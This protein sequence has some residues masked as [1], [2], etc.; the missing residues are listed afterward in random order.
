MVN[1]RKVQEAAVRF[2]AVQQARLFLGNSMP[3]TIVRKEMLDN[4]IDVVSERKMPAHKAIFKMSP[5][6]LQ[7][8]DDGFGISTVDNGNDTTDLWKA[9]SKLFT[10]SNY[11]GESDTVGAHGVGATISNLTS[12]KSSF[13]VFRGPA[14]LTSRT[15]RKYKN[16]MDDAGLVKGYQFTHGLLNGSPEEIKETQYQN[17][18]I[19]ELRDSMGENAHYFDSYLSGIN[20]QHA[21]EMNACLN[22]DQIV[23]KTFRL[24]NR[25]FEKGLDTSHMGSI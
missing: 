15:N 4:I 13:L 16:K 3:S 21:S 2:T 14:M 18:A 25:I 22:E 12:W 24:G 7:V 10:S 20:V 8:M 9:V 23:T 5:H 1:G 19:K 17:D 6:R 11:K